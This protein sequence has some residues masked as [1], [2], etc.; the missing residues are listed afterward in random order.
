[1]SNYIQGTKGSWV[2]IGAVGGQVMIKDLAGNVVWEF[3]EEKEKSEYK[4]TNPFVLEHVNM[5]NCIRKN[6]PIQQATEA[7]VSNMAGLMGRESA[8][9]G[10]ETTWEG[11]TSSGLDLTPPDLNMGTMDMSQFVVP[12]PGTGKNT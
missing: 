1:V 12:V 2:G 8:Y 10:L 6:T 4:Q 7:A 11:M 9:T 5:V 3:D